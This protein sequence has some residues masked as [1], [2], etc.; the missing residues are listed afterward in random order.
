[1][2]STVDCVRPEGIRFHME[3]NGSTAIARLLWDKAP[4]TCAAIAALLP[5]D[6]M[7]WHGRNSGAEA[8]LITPA[9]ISHLPQVHSVFK[10]IFISLLKIARSHACRMSLKMQRQRTPWVTSF[11]ALKPLDPAMVLCEG[12][13]GF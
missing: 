4:K 9:L 1:M 2:T 10:I 3:Q 12:K 8:L 13:Y 5:I 6:T 11:L 7:C